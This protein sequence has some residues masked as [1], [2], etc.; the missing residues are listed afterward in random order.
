[1]TGEQPTYRYLWP[2]IREEL[3][4]KGRRTEAVGGEPKLPVEL[5][6]ALHSLYGNYEA[7]YRQWEQSQSGRGQQPD[8]ARLHRRLQQ[9]QRLEAGLRLRRR[10][11]A[12]PAQ[13]ARRFPFPASLPFSAT[14]RTGDGKPD[15]SRS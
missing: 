7:R 12:N 6:G 10:L 3:P 15:R 1:M 8:A 14:S 5:Q 4:R 9:H 11:G 13:T 2:R